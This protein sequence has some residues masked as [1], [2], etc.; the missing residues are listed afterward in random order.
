M[1]PRDDET[2]DDDEDPDCSDCKDRFEAMAWVRFQDS[3]PS[4]LPSSLSASPTRIYQGDVSS[5]GKS[6]VELPLT[7][8]FQK[9]PSEVSP[10]SVVLLLG[11]R[12]YA[13]RARLV[14]CNNTKFSEVQI[15]VHGR[16]IGTIKHEGSLSP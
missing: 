12:D 9:R 6:I 4:K 7:K 16:A 14:L 2:N 10:T 1:R 5:A 3:G 15:L 8:F 13:R 11:L